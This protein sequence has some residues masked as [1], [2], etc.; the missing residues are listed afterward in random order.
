MAAGDVFSNLNMPVTDGAPVDVQPAVGVSIC[1]TFVSSQNNQYTY[2][3]GKNSV[4]TLS[5]F[6]TGL[7]GTG[8]R[9]DIIAQMNQTF[10]MKLF[11][12]NTQYLVFSCA[13]TTKSLAYSG[14]E[15]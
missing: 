6:T 8:A 1:I 12:T 7:N 15:I 3:G 14:I 9:N 11:I 2:F 13:D 4:G 5:S 10:N